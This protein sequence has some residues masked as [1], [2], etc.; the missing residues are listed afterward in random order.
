MVGVQQYDLVK[1][2]FECL[3]LEWALIKAKKGGTTEESLSS[4]VGMR[5]FLLFKLIGGSF[6]GRENNHG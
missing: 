2:A 4:L 6:Y 3:F 5:G 1:G